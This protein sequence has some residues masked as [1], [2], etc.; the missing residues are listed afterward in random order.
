V[1]FALES[2]DIGYSCHV[3]FPIRKHNVI[4]GAYPKKGHLK[5]NSWT[6]FVPLQKLPHVVNPS[7]GYINSANNFITSK[8]AEHGIS[9]AFAFQHRALR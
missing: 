2:G 6:G 4:Q 9:H 1:V 7:K 8:N 3:K 5:A